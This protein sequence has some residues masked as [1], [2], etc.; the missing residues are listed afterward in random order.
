[1]VVFLLFV[2]ILFLAFLVLLL[3]FFFQYL[4]DFFGREDNIRFIV[5]DDRFGIEGKR[6]KS[7][8]IRCCA[9]IGGK[10]DIRMLHEVVLFV[11]DGVFASNEKKRVAVIEHTHFFRQHEVSTG[12]GSI[13]RVAS[14]PSLGFGV[15]VGADCFLAELFRYQFMGA[16][17]VTAEVQKLIAVADDAFPLLVKQGFELGDVLNDYAHADFP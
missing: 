14:V 2:L 11:H 4:L 7:V 15:A 3:S 1:M 12:Q 17:F 6:G 16:V 5:K 13:L 8:F 9:A 10:S